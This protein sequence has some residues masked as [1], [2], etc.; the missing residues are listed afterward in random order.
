MSEYQYSDYYAGRALVERRMM[1]AAS[2]PRALA[3][4]AELAAR[5]E[6]LAAFPSLD[7]PS[8]RSPGG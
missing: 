6:A 8:H 5:Y 1:E 2:D 4:H 3:S 7:L